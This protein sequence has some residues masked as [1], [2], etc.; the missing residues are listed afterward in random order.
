MKKI[1]SFAAVSV[2]LVCAAFIYSCQKEKAPVPATQQP[3]ELQNSESLDRAGV[4]STINI[5]LAR[6]LTI[7]GTDTGV[8]QCTT[9]NGQQR[10]SEV[11]ATDAESYG[12]IGSSA[13]TL[14]NPNGF[15]VTVGLYFNC[16]LQSPIWVTVPANNGILR[17]TVAPNA[18]G[19]CVI[20]PC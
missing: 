15:P 8:M 20:T 7:C 6:G 3:V 4:C 19:C 5:V 2:L 14:T 1:F 17:F 10:F 12:F 9:C 13:F 16:G 18:Q 11:I